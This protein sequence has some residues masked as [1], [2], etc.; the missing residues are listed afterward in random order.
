MWLES[1]P[2]VGDLFEFDENYAFDASD[3]MRNLGTSASAGAQMTFSGVTFGEGAARQSATLTFADTANGTF[4]F[5]AAGELSLYEGDVAGVVEFNFFG[6]YSF[7]V[8]TLSRIDFA[9]E[10]DGDLAVIKFSDFAEL[11]SWSLSGAG[12]RSISGLG[13]GLYAIFVESPGGYGLERTGAGVSTFEQTFTLGFA[14]SE[15]AVPE[16]GTWA[17][18]IAGFGLTGSVL[19]RA[20][21]APLRVTA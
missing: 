3:T 2:G 12:S 21:R 17:L 16:P 10:G 13:P 8:D 5:D 19:R 15:A 9:F 6:Q 1:P 18:M 20:G 11:Q 14:I 4:A 7:W